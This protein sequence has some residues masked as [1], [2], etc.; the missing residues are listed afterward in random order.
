[1]PEV[2]HDQVLAKRLIVHRSFNTTLTALKNTNIRLPSEPSPVSMD[3]QWINSGPTDDLVVN[4]EEIGGYSLNAKA[5][6]TVAKDSRTLIAGYD[7][8]INKFSALEG[9]AYYTSHSLVFL[10]PE[11]YIPVNQL[12]MYFFT[13]SEELS[14]RSKG[15]LIYS[16]QPS[17]QS[18]KM[19]LDDKVDFIF[20]S[21]PS[22]SI[23]FIDGPLIAGD[24]YT[25]LIS[26]FPG[27][28]ERNII[29]CFFVKNS[30]SNMVVDNIEN[31][32]GRY[33]SDLHW[34]HSTLKNGQRSCF[35]KYVDRKNARNTK[36]FC[37]LKAFGISP[38][39][40]EFYTTSF[41]KYSDY[42]NDIMDLIYYL[43]LVQ[44]DLKNPQIR[45]IA[46][47]ESYARETLKIVNFE[48]TM[49]MAGLM[50]TM[51]QERFA[52]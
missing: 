35:F 27:F 21:V 32:R 28:H 39:R 11:S 24:V 6:E 17:I 36:V 50:P 15:A 38:L 29:P 7:E 43:L 5:G 26:K 12:T 49:R 16:T 40:I 33:N 14:L 23:L 18:Q 46:I 42:I 9:T 25:H 1:M 37:Y 51:N 41:D 30:D 8:S 48:Q 4:L 10:A 34:G 31:I 3:Y 52:W 19:Y 22:N 13:R 44:G 20:S 2:T 47:A 45:P